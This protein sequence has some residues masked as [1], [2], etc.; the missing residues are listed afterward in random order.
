MRERLAE[1][2]EWLRSRRVTAIG[3][4]N[5]MF[6]VTSEALGTSSY[7]LGDVRRALSEALGLSDEEMASRPYCQGELREPAAY[8]VPKIAQLA[9]VMEHCEIAEVGFCPSIGSCAGLLISED[10]Y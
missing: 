1:P 7:S 10:R 6:C 4:P 5:S 8:I 3:G 9:A 2:A